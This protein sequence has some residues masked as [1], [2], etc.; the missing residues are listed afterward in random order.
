[1]SRRALCALASLLACGFAL[2]GGLAGSA[3][4]GVSHSRIA[5]HGRAGWRGDP[6]FAISKVVLVFKDHSRSVKYPGHHREPRTLVTVIRYPA[7]RTQ[8][9]FPLII[10][11]HGFDITPGPYR[12]LLEAWAR[13]GYVVAAPIF[14]L[15][16]SKTP[17]GPQ[18]SDLVNQPADVSFVIGRMLA[19]SAARRGRLAGM[20]DPRHIAVSGQSDGGSTALA[21]AYNRHYVDHRI[22]AAMILSGAEIPG[23]SGYTFPAPAPPLLAVQGTADTTNAPAS[24]YR[25]FRIASRPK[26][27]LRLWGA[28][29]LGPYTNQQ[30]QLRIVERE[31]IAFLDRYL[32]HLR[33]ATTRMWKDG[34]VP[35][36]ATLSTHSPP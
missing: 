36:L 27:L 10:F 30:P 4:A 31:T 7:D 11:A 2:A 20:I 14:P 15:T 25:Y 16:S 24:T 8:G 29:H 21:V 17:G 32:K 6:R 18:E 34:K 5:L 23:V 9:P 35:G 19:A 33:G 28:S 22:R 13:A 3:A 12:R 1:M 26:F